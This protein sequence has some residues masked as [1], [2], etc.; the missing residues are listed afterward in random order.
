MTALKLRAT[1][2]TERVFTAPVY[3]I[4]SD[5]STDAGDGLRSRRS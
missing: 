4:Q 1:S 5:S 3:L 2:V